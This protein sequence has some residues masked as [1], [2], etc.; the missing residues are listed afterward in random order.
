MPL[1]G[2]ID[3]LEYL[4]KTSGSMQ[5]AAEFGKAAQDAAAS[6]TDLQIK[7]LA[8]KQAS[9]AEQRKTAFR[10]K[11]VELAANPTA[12]GYNAAQLEYPEFASLIAK[13]IADL[14]VKQ[15]SELEAQMLPVH[16]A[17]MKGRPDLALGHM[18]Q[19]AKAYENSGQPEKAAGIRSL[20]E[21]GKTNPDFVVSTLGG[22][23]NG[24][25]GEKRF[26]SY[27]ASLGLRDKLREQKAKTDRAATQAESQPGLDAAEIAR[28]Q[29]AT[30]S[31]GASAANALA[32]A[33]RTKALLPYEKGQMEA[34]AYRSTAAGDR[35]WA[36]IEGI[37]A[38]AEAKKIDQQQGQQRIEN[39]KRRLDQVE[40]R[41]PVE[42]RKLYQ[43]SQAVVDK[44][45]TAMAFADKL[46]RGIAAY[47]PVGGIRG[48][49]AE[50]FKKFM[51]W[52]NKESELKQQYVGVM[53]SRVL[54]LI[55]PGSLSDAEGKT[56]RE[57]FPPS[58]ADADTLYNFVS[59]LA[60]LK[61][62][63]IA[64][65]GLRLRWLRDNHSL[66]QPASKSFKSGP[67]TVNKGDYMDEMTGQIIS[68][69]ESAVSNTGSAVPRSSTWTPEKEKELADL[70]RLAGGTK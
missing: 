64:Y 39:E 7:Q 12:A 16:N 3:P 29:A 28:R 45:P 31:L 67:F 15:K 41:M 40:K 44:A 42:D 10:A 32:S 14:N 70:R 50:A 1:L 17:Y 58:N 48:S 27:V 49:S 21:Q 18:S 24:V 69:A 60:K 36:E 30:V 55:P 57:G 23:L 9:D 20:L 34:N 63:D 8:L 51:G 46:A 25:M 66:R 52:Q 22:Y 59:G 61:K 13:P 26:D 56:L 2:P 53:N 65:H 62:A 6:A 19:L 68:N 37:P 35:D 43:E 38:K 33:N 54:D 5:R 47:R 4:P 11:M